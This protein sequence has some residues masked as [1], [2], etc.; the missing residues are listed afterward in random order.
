LEIKIS[1]VINCIGSEL[2]PKVSE[3]ILRDI[4]KQNFS[5]Y[6]LQI[7][8]LSRMYN[9]NSEDSRLN[10]SRF[11]IDTKES[12]DKFLKYITYN[13]I[14]GILTIKRESR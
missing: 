10:Y 13:T 7:K 1:K 2:F 9:F 14:Y 6:Q 8:D 12:Y 4:I 11:I 5:E 3:E